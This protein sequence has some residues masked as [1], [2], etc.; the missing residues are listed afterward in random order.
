MAAMHKMPFIIVLTAWM[1]GGTLYA[2]Q[3]AKPKP[4]AK[5]P[6]ACTLVKATE[7]GQILGTSIANGVPHTDERA[8]V[9]IFLSR[10]GD[11]VDIFVHRTQDKRDLNSLLAQAKKALP[12]STTVREV[13]NLGEK[14]LMVEDT[15]GS[16][17]VSVYRGG[18][19]FVVAVLKKT[20]GTK[21]DVAAEKIA[22]LAYRHF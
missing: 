4:A 19:S 20:S 11:R 17:A 18:D 5:P 9:C 8:D 22:R 14:A 12:K 7:I 13:P 16:A 3:Q 21:A 15:P 6:G 1:V 10:E 2:A